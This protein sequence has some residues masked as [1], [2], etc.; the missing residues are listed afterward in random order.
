MKHSQCLAEGYDEI[1]GGY[2][3]I[4]FALS[5]FPLNG[6]CFDMSE[7]DRCSQRNV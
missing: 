2:L 1:S 7:M 4:Y 6:T 3:F 5:V